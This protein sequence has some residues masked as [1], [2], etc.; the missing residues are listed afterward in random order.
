MET[1]RTAGMARWL[2]GR[3]GGRSVVD[4]VMV[5]GSLAERCWLEVKSENRRGSW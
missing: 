4:G 1:W 2:C 5:H 3:H